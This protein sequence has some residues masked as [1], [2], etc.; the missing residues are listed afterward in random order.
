M[1]TTPFSRWAEIR[2]TPRCCC[3]ALAPPLFAHQ[4]V[5]VRII[6]YRNSRYKTHPIFSLSFLPFQSFHSRQASL[7]NGSHTYFIR[8]ER[9]CESHSAVLTLPLTT[10]QVLPLLP[11]RTYHS[12]TCC[13]CPLS[14][15]PCG[16]AFACLCVPSQSPPPLFPRDALIQA[17]DTHSCDNSSGW[18]DV[19]PRYHESSFCSSPRDVLISGVLSDAP[20]KGTN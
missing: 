17:L 1:T 20:L 6:F 4:S 14:S 13:C 10:Y 11:S 12:F 15:L 3:S 5:Q 8:R 16:T 9:W 2:T 19:M 7:T 18:R